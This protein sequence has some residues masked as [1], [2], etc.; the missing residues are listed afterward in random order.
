MSMYE[1]IAYDSE[2]DDDL[3]YYSGALVLG[4]DSDKDFT[5]SHWMIDGGCTDHLTPFKDDFVHLGT[6]VHSASV[7][8]GQTVPM[9][10]PGKIILQGFKGSEPIILDEVWYAPHAAHRLLSVNTLT[11]QGYTSRCV[12][13]DQESRIW[14]TSGTL[15]IWAA[16]SSPRNNLHWF[17]S[18]SITPKKVV[19]IGLCD[20]RSINSLVKEDSYELWHQ[21]FGH[22]SRSA[23]RQ[24]PSR[25]TGLPSI[26]LPDSIPPCKGCALGKMH[27]RSY[28]PS[29]KQ[30]S[31]PLA[32]VHTDLVRPMPVGPHL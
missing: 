6:A 4:G 31:H 16:A 11:G 15:V 19:T 9:Y 30:A 3:C 20:H 18:Q 1:T 29:G 13:N 25:V 27:N 28:P 26:I 12:I 32:L 2:N 5:K 21:H 23:L 10:G 7:A 22:L 17:Q 14:N 24:A 8:N